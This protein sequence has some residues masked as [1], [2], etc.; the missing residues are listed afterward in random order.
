MIDL[1][2]AQAQEDLAS[3]IFSVRGQ[4]EVSIFVVD[5]DPGALNS[6]RFLLESEGSPR[7]GTDKTSS[8]S[9]P[10]AIRAALSLLQNA[11]HE[12]A[13]NLLAPAPA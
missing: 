2:L 7:S 5:D 4:P 10:R 6:L 9:S 13:R 11:E 8:Q 1:K 3:D 12:R